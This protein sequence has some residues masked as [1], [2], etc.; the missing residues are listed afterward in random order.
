MASL[1][2][3]LGETAKAVLHLKDLGRIFVPCKVDVEVIDSAINVHNDGLSLER[4][5]SLPP[6]ELDLSLLVLVDVANSSMLPHSLAEVR[7]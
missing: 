4:A 3:I 2:P 7:L 1:E 6:I 5:P